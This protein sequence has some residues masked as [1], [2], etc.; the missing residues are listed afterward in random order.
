MKKIIVGVTGSIA[1][2]KSAEFVRA[3]RQRDIEVQVVMTEHAKSFITPLTLQAL[4]GKPVLSEWCAAET[5]EGMDHIALARWADAI[6]CVPASADFIARLTHGLANDLLTTLCLATTAPIYIAPAMNPNMW[7]HA[8]TQDNVA[9]LKKRHVQFIG[10]ACGEHACGE[11]GLGRMVETSDIINALFSNNSLAGQH[12]LITAGPTQEA[13]DPVRYISN[14]SS[15]KMG[16]ALAEAAYRAGA[17]VTV[18]TG[19]VSLSLSKDIQRIDVISANDMLNAVLHHSPTSTIFISAAA[20]GDY[21]AEQMSDQ[22]I[23]KLTNTLSLSLIPTPDILKTLA[24]QNHLFTVGFALETQ[25][26]MANAEKKLKSK[27]IDMIIANELSENT[28]FNADTNAVKVLFSDGKK[29]EFP[30]MSKSELA[31]QLILRIAAQC[32]AK[33]TVA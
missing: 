2:Y 11:E 25:D 14:R 26:L 1:A 32:I 15:G 3:L 21:Q 20:V 7:S 28:G 13:I 6:V 31:Q 29:E 19:P 8:A 9:L 24:Q 18:I 4:S 12:V 5:Q 30:L 22:K 17:K 16:F 33:R 23:K 10:P 27:N